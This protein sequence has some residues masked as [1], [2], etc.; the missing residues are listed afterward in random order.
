MGTM[1]KLSQMFMMGGVQ[2]KLPKEMR[3]K[4]AERKPIRNPL[5]NENKA[6][7]DRYYG[8]VR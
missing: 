7:L 5:S 2:V 3:D 1:R 8:K 6:I 4:E